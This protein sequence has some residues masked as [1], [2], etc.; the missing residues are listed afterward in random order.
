MEIDFRDGNLEAIEKDE[1]F[2]GG[3]SPGIAA[4]IRQRIRHIRAAIDE[5]PLR[6]MKSLHFEKLKGKRDHQ[7]SIRLNDQW[8]LIIEL[9]KETNPKTVVIVCVEDYH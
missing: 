1:G 8:R 6:A 2:D 7:H 5:R 9:D 4:K 3:Y